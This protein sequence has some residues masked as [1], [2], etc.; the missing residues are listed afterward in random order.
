MFP[1]LLAALR[2][3]FD[4]LLSPVSVG[5]DIGRGTVRVVALERRAG[6][7]RLAGLA[8]AEF[9]AA[10]PAPRTLAA[11]VRRACRDL[12]WRPRRIVSAVAASTVLVRALEVPST[13]AEGVFD[14]ALES[15][16]RGLPLPASTLRI[17]WADV[18]DGWDDPAAP[19]R[20]GAIASEP[21]QP[22]GAIL[23]AVRRE[24]A[25]GLQ[26]LLML[27]GL[28]R[29]LID[30]DAF[31][32][33]RATLHGGS[34]TDTPILLVDAGSDSLRALAWVPGSVPVLRVAPATRGARAA[35]LAATVGA[36]AREVAPALPLPVTGIVLAGGG[37][38]VEGLA[39]SVTTHTGLPCA[40]ADPFRRLAADAADSTAPS[41]PSLPPALWLVACGLALR[42][43]A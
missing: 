36:L 32:A 25:A 28:G 40:L 35:D 14:E 22:S 39:A 41:A 43:L 26:R 12:P 7:L 4:A 20:S 21:R 42:G 37:A 33:L 38:L 34:D 29:G 1:L 19:G 5:I 11:V 9:A 3:H 18:G 27:A 16:L 10:M 23:V 15:A 24:A 6:R 17:V 30:I 2:E 8:S 13:A 31:A